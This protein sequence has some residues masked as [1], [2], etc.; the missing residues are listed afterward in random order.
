MAPFGVLGDRI[1]AALETLRLF[2][3]MTLRQEELER[4]ISERKRAEEERERLI[5]ELQETL[6]T[7]KTLSGLLP[8][9]AWCKRIRTDKGYWTALEEYLREH[10][11]IVLT[12][13][14]CPACAEE[15][16]AE[17]NERQ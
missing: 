4:E 16:S 1:G 12:H 2:D 9:C 11:D 15:L 14:I 8:I 5:A 17:L 6:A 7:V 3:E 13:G 10:T